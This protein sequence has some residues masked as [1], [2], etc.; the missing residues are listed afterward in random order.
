MFMARHCMEAGLFA[1]DDITC[2]TAFKVDKSGNETVLHSFGDSQE[3]GI[4][5]FGVVRDAE[6]NLYGM[7]G[8]GGTTGGGTIYQ[9]DSTGNETIL[10]SFPGGSVGYLPDSTLLR[11]AA[12]NLYGTTWAGGNSYYG[13][14]FKFTPRSPRPHSNTERPGASLPR[15]PP[16]AS[17]DTSRPPALQTAYQ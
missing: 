4:W 16:S 14:F 6:G 8:S 1:P 5:P 17:F 15:P 11:D 3:D 2:G 7:T 13:T 12:G 9:L 10:Y